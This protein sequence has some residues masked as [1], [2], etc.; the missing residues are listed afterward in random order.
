MML[1]ALCI[2]GMTFGSLWGA[3]NLQSLANTEQGALAGAAIGAGSGKLVGPAI[4]AA[5]ICDQPPDIPEILR[6]MPSVSAGVPGV[7]EVF[8]DDIE[9]VSEKL[10]DRVD[11]P[12]FFP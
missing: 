5:P 9:I 3:G 2:A 7:F 12:R 1:E 4:G 6:A 8:R 10:V 11:V